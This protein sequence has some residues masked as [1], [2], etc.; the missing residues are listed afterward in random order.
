MVDAHLLFRAVSSTVSLAPHAMLQTSLL[1]LR[2]HCSRSLCCC[3]L[4]RTAQSC[5][6]VC[7]AVHASRDIKHVLPS[8]G[9][10][11]GA[12]EFPRRCFDTDEYGIGL[13]RERRLHGHVTFA[14]D[15]LR[16]YMCS[17]WSRVS[18][19]VSGTREKMRCTA[20]WH[21]V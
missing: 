21:S 4:Q 3:C 8:C 6:H 5:S 10:M 11:L 17:T 18:S 9:S 15:A 14:T 16:P 2:G 13:L 7:G 19:E 12:F 1:I 20:T